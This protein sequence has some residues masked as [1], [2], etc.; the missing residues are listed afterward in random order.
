[1]RLAI[2][3]LYNQTPNQGMKGIKNILDTFAKG[4]EFHYDIFDVRAK[5]EIPGLHY[6]AYI[7]T[8]GPGNPHYKKEDGDPIWG[9]NWSNWM[10]S[11]LK[12]NQET[13]GIK[14]QVFLI[15]HSFQMMCIHTKV[16]VVALRKSPS[17]GI[18]PMHKTPD[19]ELEPLFFGIDNPFYAIDSRKYQVLDPNREIMDK[20]DMKILAYEKIRPHVPYDR[21]IMA[22]R[23]TNE[24]IGTQFH[25]EGDPITMKHYFSSPEKKEEI[26]KEHG[27]KKYQDML[28]SLDD[29][30]RIEK[31]FY[32]LLPEF[33]EKSYDLLSLQISTK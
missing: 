1:M 26:I 17:F 10:D 13:E 2:L 4:K 19:G 27:K 33:L 15:C 16:A 25:P 12:F 11:I 28:I 31:T 22:I 3:D 9:K 30:N 32:H 5:D 8:G 23:F 24:I 20:W 29:P 6:D 7:S 21:A 18:F 14:K